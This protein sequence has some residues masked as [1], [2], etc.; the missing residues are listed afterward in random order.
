MP[1]EDSIEVYVRGVGSTDAPELIGHLWEA[2]S[3]IC[4][5]SPLLNTDGHATTGVG[6]HLHKQIGYLEESEKS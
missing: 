6:H 1:A 5:F 4:G 2:D 3:E